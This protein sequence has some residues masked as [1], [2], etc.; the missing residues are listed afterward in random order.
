M[1]ANNDK[2]TLKD[3]YDAVDGLRSDIGSNYVTKD[4]FT[5]VRNIVYGLVATILLS[6]IAAVIALV[7]KTK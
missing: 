7:I 6:F 2:V 5:P 3:V 4:A 1:A